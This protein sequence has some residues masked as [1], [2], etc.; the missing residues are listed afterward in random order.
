M[1][2]AYARSCCDAFVTLFSG[3]ARWCCTA[4]L[5]GSSKRLGYLGVVWRNLTP[6]CCVAVAL[7]AAVGVGAVVGERMELAAGGKAAFHTAASRSL[8]AYNVYAPPSGV[9]DAQ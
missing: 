1:V 6:W 5:L 4:V 3:V 2:R 9:G 8:G 7:C